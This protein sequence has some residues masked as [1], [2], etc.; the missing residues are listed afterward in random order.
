MS[1]SIRPHSRYA[2]LD[3]WRGVA[4]LLVLVNHSVFYTAE[5]VRASVSLTAVNQLIATI[6]TRAWAGVPLFFVISG[7]CITATIDSHRRKDGSVG[8]YFWK[9][10][11]RIFPPYWAT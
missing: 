10:F 2:T 5:T 7:Y 9:R 4:C 11:R 3:M 1:E 8:T 6:A